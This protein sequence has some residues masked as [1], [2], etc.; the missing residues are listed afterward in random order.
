MG[1]RMAI[2]VGLVAGVLVGGL[3][4]GAYVVYGPE[5][6]GT[7][8]PSVPASASASASPSPSAS[9]GR[10]GSP[11]P[12][13]G[14]SG[15]PVPTPA[16]SEDLGAAFHIGQ[17][18]PPLRVARLGGGEPIDLAG[19]R[20]KPV[21]VVFMATWCPSCVDEFPVMNGFAARYEEEGLVVIAVDL[22]EP[23]DQVAAFVGQFNVVFPVG[24]DPDGVAADAWGVLVPPIHFWVD[25]EGVIRD[26]ALGG[27]GPDIMATAL[28]RVMP[29]VDVEP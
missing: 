23:E 16:A 6:L 8:V 17:P 19:L 26:G 13:P 5:L 3:A 21:W 7:P 29:G 4:L 22:Q 11:T 9:P 10:T 27:I 28:E 25:T 12:T 24:L 1:S 20:G 18:A 15:T 2:L 14:T